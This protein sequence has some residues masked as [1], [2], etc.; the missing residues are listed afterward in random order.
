MDHAENKLHGRVVAKFGSIANF[1]QACKIN[2]SKAYRMITGC[3]TRTEKDI[4]FLIRE[5]DI[6]EAEDVVTLFSLL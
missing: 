2:Y 3:Q 6:D 5:L 1:A 4:R